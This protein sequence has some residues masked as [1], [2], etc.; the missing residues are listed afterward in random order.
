MLHEL[1]KRE[2]SLWATL[3]RES[4][5]EMVSIS[6]EGLHSKWELAGRTLF[7]DFITDGGLIKLIIVPQ[8]LSSQL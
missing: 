5:L 6:D 1:L 2:V 8:V 4:F 3:A 7:N